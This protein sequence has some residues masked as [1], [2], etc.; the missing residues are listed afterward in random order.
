MLV[1][2]AADVMGNLAAGAAVA[3]VVDAGI[4]GLAAGVAVGN[5]GLAAGVVGIEGL[6]DANGVVGARISTTAT[7]YPALRRRPLA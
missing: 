5:E 1:G 4:A 2:V 7:A 3:G 6:D